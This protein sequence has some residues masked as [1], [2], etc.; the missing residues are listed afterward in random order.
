M[1]EEIHNDIKV[2]MLQAEA[3]EHERRYAEAE[4]L[5]L[6]AVSRLP[7][8]TFLKGSLLINAGQVAQLDGRID[9]AHAHYS[10]A[11]SVLEGQRGEA[12]LECGNAYLNVARIRLM[13]EM[14]GAGAAALNAIRI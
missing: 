4:R 2:L 1:F 6:N 7:D 9:D 11:V 13:K 14:D 5:W 8:R 3:C 10:K 12:V